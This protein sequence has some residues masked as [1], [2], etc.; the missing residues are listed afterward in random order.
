MC[1]LVV[2]CGFMV[3]N[4]LEVAGTLS[5]MLPTIDEDIDRIEDVSATP[6]MDEEG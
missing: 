4:K 6:L 2:I 1:V 3:Y 5:F